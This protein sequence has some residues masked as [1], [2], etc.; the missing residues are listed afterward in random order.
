MN[1]I[2]HE[3]VFNKWLL[4]EHRSY[5]SSINLRGISFIPKV[6]ALRDHPLP[7]FKN[8]CV[9]ILRYTMDLLFHGPVISKPDCVLS[10]TVCCSWSCSSRRAGQDD[11]QRRLPTS[12]VCD[13]QLQ[14]TAFLSTQILQL[15]LAD[16]FFPLTSR[17]LS[18]CVS[19]K[20]LPVGADGLWRPLP[21]SILFQ[22]SRSPPKQWQKKCFHILHLCL[23]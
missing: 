15:Q 10:W 14:V 23:K 22:S 6:P 8:S 9:F 11:L 21:S 13:I 4:P 7:V 19:M 1:P 2:S 17:T 18:L 5:F 12:L 20:P 16:A 3:N